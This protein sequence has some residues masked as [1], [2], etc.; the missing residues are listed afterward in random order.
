MRINEVLTS[1]GAKYQALY[2]KHYKKAYVQALK[3]GH[4]PDDARTY[5]NKSLENYKEKIRTGEWDPITR[6]KG[7]GQAEYK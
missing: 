5:A 4:S 3:L 7:L 2:T 6:K 1:V